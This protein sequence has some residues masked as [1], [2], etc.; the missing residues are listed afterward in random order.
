MTGKADTNSARGWYE[1]EHKLL[2]Q[3][4]KDKG[5]GTIV[6]LFVPIRLSRDD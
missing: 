1:G 4:D 6:E 2:Q 5:G 3:R